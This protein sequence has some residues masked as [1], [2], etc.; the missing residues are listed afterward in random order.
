MYNYEKATIHTAMFN[1]FLCGEAAGIL[2]DRRFK[3]KDPFEGK[4]EVGCIDKE[5]CQK[6][7]GYMKEGVILIS[8]Q[9]GS[10]KDNPH[11]TGGWCVITYEA[12]ERIF[13]EVF[14]EEAARPILEKRVGFVEDE[15]WDMLN[16][17]RGE[18]EG[19]PSE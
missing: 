8:A 10:D 14:G 16:L 15:V 11:R 3:V 18:V 7:K 1:C 6:C 9:A 17:P 2:L 12:A 4:R 19:V 13:T 5:P